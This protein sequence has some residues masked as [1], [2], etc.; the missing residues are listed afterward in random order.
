MRPSCELAAN[1]CTVQGVSCEGLQPVCPEPCRPWQC[2]AWA[3]LV[4]S[5]GVS[6][7]SKRACGSRGWLPEESMQAARSILCRQWQWGARRQEAG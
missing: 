7:G 3:G 5:E 2:R 4:S 6:A 1:A